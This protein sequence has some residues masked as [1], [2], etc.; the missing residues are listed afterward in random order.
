MKL[1]DLLRHIA[2]NVENG[3]IWSEGI[4][5]SDEA[6]WEDSVFFGSASSVKLTPRTREV[7]GFTVPA[8]VRE[9]IKNGSVYYVEDPTDSCWYVAH[10]WGGGDLDKRFLERGLIHLNQDSAIANAK[11]HRGID[12]KWGEE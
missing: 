12:P 7:N 10:S 4:D 8:P 2:D 6:A 5:I 9:P 1:H 3:E 11:A